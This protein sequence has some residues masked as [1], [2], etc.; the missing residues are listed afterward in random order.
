MDDVGSNPTPDTHHPRPVRKGPRAAA[1]KAP[2][3][4]PA[5]VKDPAV[6][7]PPRITH[8][9]TCRDSADCPGAITGHGYFDFT[10]EA[11]EKP[12]GRRH[13][14]KRRGFKSVEAAQAAISALEA[15]IPLVGHRRSRTRAYWLAAAG[16]LLEDLPAVTLSRSAD[17]FVYVF[18]AD[19]YLK[20]GYSESPGTRL[21]SLRQKSTLLKPADL[22]H[23]SITRW[24]EVPGSRKDERVLHWLARNYQ[25]C[26][27]W[28]H[29]DA[30]LM[31]ALKSCI[32]VGELAVA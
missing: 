26:G 20:I 23:A 11:G 32:R 28:F 19:Y 7:L 30:A 29:A 31:D 18:R 27:E 3:P 5:A 16:M 4:V 10:I 8:R 15:V 22:N 2:V 25:A 9:C 17:G 14:I 1:G 6:A 13:Q 12:D 21:Y 24:L